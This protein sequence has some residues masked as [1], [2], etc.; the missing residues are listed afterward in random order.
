[1]NRIDQIVEKVAARGKKKKEDKEEGLIKKFISVFE[2]VKDEI[3]GLDLKEMKEKVIS[4]ISGAK[5]VEQTD[6][7]E[8]ID[9]VNSKHDE[10]SLMRYVWE[11]YVKY[12]WPELAV[13]P[14]RRGYPRK[15]IKLTYNLRLKVAEKLDEVAAMLE[16]YKSKKCACPMCQCQDLPEFTEDMPVFFIIQEMPTFTPHVPFEPTE[17]PDFN[18]QDMPTLA[19]E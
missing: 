18:I 13:I 4:A 14:T 10:E 7:N 3:E 11:S 15:S 9:I 17:M 2:T 5:N 8:M 19:E 6:K 1:M 12:N 16:H